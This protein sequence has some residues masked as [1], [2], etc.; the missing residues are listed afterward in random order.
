AWHVYGVLAFADLGSKLCQER[1]IRL[2]EI[3]SDI[4]LTRRFNQL[5]RQ[6]DSTGIALSRISLQLLSQVWKADGK[7]PTL[8]LA[9]KHGG[10]NRYDELLSEITDGEFIVRKEEGLELSRYKV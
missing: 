5:T 8:I 2:R 10:R 4:V 1:G 6:H 7:E 9:D 3:R